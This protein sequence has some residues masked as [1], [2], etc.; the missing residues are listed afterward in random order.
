METSISGSGSLISCPSLSRT[1]ESLGMWTG[2]SK[3]WR[4]Q[5]SYAWVFR[6]QADAAESWLL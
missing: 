6:P 5:E 1:E 3:Q 4:N 2:Q